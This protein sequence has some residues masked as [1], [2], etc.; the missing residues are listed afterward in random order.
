MARAIGRR[1]GVRHRELNDRLPEHAANACLARRASDLLLEVIHVGIRRRTRL[2]HLEGGES[3]AGAHEFRA[4][5]LGLSR[6][7]VLLQ[8]VHQREIVR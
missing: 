2:D 7:N 5:G 4:D 8:P 6:E 3:R 1:L